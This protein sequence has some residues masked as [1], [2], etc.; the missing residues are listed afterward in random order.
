MAAVSYN[1]VESEKKKLPKPTSW[2]D[3][4]KPEYKG[5]ITMANPA[6]SGTGFLSV[7]GWLQQIGEK[8]AWPFMDKLNENIAASTHS[9]SK[10][11]KQAAAGE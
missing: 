5:M 3:L 4:N 7:S 2:A 6:S 11:C 8:Q 9:G 1:T 10:P